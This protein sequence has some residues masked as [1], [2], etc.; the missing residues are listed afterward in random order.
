ML[1]PKTAVQ[2]CL[3]FLAAVAA[4][5]WGEVVGAPRSGSIDVA[6]EVGFD[7]RFR[8]GTWTPLG[9]TISNEG[10]PLHGAMEIAVRQSHL[11]SQPAP[12]TLYLYAL[13]LPTHS[14][15]RWVITMPVN[16][17]YDPI[18]LRLRE[19]DEIVLAR[20]LPVR[21]S[22]STARFWLVLDRRAAGWN[23]LSRA[24]RGSREEVLY[25]SDPGLLPD[26]WTAYSALEALIIGE[27]PLERIS[28]EQAEA[29]RQWTALGGRILLAPG[30]SAPLSAPAA[31]QA[32][33]PVRLTGRTE[34]ASLAPLAEGYTPLGDPDQAAVLEGIRTDSQLIAGSDELPLAAV[35]RV[36]LGRVAFLAADPT[37][38]PLLGWAGLGPLVRDLVGVSDREGRLLARSRNLEEG[39][40][41]VLRDQQLGTVSRTAALVY[42]GA[43][44]ALLLAFTVSARRRPGW[45]AL[46]ALAGV[47][48]AALGYAVFS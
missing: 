10:P 17:S 46:S 25:V 15:K 38:P 43:W 9:I 8:P 6:V 47:A 24:E 5:A 37:A 33:W 29:I 4:P 14:R 12:T 31:L 19:G 13:D 16:Q 45:W 11:I 42:W 32:L 39:I 36:G 1:I 26:A 27:F 28:E 20:E 23:F 34:R 21:S 40:W 3:L 35:R 2:L 44:G 48:A 30:A 18:T 22:A 41:P 7:G